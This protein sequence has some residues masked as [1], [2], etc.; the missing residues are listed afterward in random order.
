MTEQNQT[1]FLR[2]PEVTRIT[3]L[4]RDSVYRLA[5][6][7]RFPRPVKLSERA[8]GWVLSEVEAWAA[9]RASERGAA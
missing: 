4:Q 5:K 2:L 3:G 6:A 1:R 9:A 8:S 7:G